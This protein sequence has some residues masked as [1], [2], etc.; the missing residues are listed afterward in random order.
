MRITLKNVQDNLNVLDD[1]TCSFSTGITY[2]VGKNGA[3]KSSLLKLIATATEPTQ[4]EIIFTKLNREEMYRKQLRMEE[5]RT[6]I[7]YMPQH[8]TGHQEMTIKRYV[9]YIALH[10]GIP[11]HLVKPIVEKWLQETGLFLLQKRKLK[12]LSGGQLQKVGLI[13]ALINQPRICIL[14]EP[15]ESL[16]IEEKLYFQR[17][18]QRLSFHSIVLFSTHLIEEIRYNEG[19]V[20]YLNAGKLTFHGGVNESEF[21]WRTLQEEDSTCI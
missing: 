15:F 1:I 9:T 4:G 10:K 14:D 8:F 12:E 17:V 21:V 13:Q 7:G 18:L 11:Y 19:D 6:M 20:L 16:D 2:V 5:V 3:G